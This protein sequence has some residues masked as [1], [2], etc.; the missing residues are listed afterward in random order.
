VPER[1]PR[2]LSGAVGRL[3]TN[4]APPTLLAK[5]QDCWSGAVGAT[6]SEQATPTSER[7]GVVVVS[8]RSAVWS[9]ELEMLSRTLLDQLNEAL[10]ADAEVKGLKFVTKPS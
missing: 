1:G 10:P 9:S 3:R 4:L 8:C 7:D 5:V 2:S 6:V